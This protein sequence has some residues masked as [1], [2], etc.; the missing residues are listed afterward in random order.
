MGFPLTKT[1]PLRLAIVLAFV[2]FF[3]APAVFAAASGPDLLKAKKDAEARGYTFE[4]S[5]D[6]IVAKAK[7]EGKLRV[8][9]TLDPDVV[10]AAQQVFLK[11][12]PFITD[13]RLEELVDVEANQ[14]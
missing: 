2:A 4:T 8:T 7:K 3:F 9:H 14:R 5:H 10:K 11:K 6:D 12:Y 1:I 13:F